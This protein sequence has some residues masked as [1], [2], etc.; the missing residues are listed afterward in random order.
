V[1]QD[2]FARAIQKVGVVLPDSM[3]SFPPS[4]SQTRKLTWVPF[5]T[6]E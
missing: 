1:T 3:V 5:R 2:Q 4:L 6:S